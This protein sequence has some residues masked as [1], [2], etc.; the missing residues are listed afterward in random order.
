MTYHDTRTSL[1]ICTATMIALRPT[2]GRQS[3]EYFPTARALQYQAVQ[4][5]LG[6][7]TFHCFLCLWK[8]PTLCSRTSIML[9]NGTKV[10]S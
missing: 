7:Y 8:A 3:V 1:K 9:C 2:N 4:Q 5:P 6:N 10:C